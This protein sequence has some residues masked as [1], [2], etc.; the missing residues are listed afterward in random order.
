MPVSLSY[1]KDPVFINLAFYWKYLT[2]DTNFPFSSIILM[3]ERCNDIE[4]FPYL[5]PDNCIEL[6]IN[7]AIV[8][9]MNSDLTSDITKDN[10]SPLYTLTF[11]DSFRD[12][13]SFKNIKDIIFRI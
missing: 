13:N 6:Y 7:D 4:N 12:I 9:T 5:L 2:E 3:F 8:N 10:W 11:N 1:T